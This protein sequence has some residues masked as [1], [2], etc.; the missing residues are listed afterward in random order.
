MEGRLGIATSDKNNLAEPWRD[1]FVFCAFGTH[2]WNRGHV[3]I[4]TKRTWLMSAFRAMAQR[5]ANNGNCIE[6]LWQHIADHF[7][8]TLETNSRVFWD[9]QRRGTIDVDGRQ[10]HQA[11]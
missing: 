7:G 4:G 3:A 9:L 6:Y 5:A 11:K 2:S 10:A 8:V 1:W